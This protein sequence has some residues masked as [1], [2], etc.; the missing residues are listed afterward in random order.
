MN[1]NMCNWLIKSIF[2]I[3]MPISMQ[4]LTEFNLLYLIIVT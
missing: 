4:G 3:Q 2:V 1:F